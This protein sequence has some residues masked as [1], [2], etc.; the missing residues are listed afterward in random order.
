MASSKLPGSLMSF[1]GRI[2]R[3]INDVKVQCKYL[4][5]GKE[6][7]NTPRLIAWVRNR[8]DIRLERTHSLQRAR[9]W[10]GETIPCYRRI[11]V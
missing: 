11:I 2:R 7:D 10:R 6:R 1:K 9:I 5:F 4:F 8:I 3:A